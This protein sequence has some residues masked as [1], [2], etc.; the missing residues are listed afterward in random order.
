MISNGVEIIT[1][2]AAESTSLPREASG[3]LL[4]LVA[5]ETVQGSVR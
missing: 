5:H 1:S 3:G 2:G 4:S